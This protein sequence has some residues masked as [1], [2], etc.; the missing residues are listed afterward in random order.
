MKIEI[1]EVSSKKE[2][3]QFVKFPLSLYKGNNYYVPSLISE[4]MNS[5]DNTKNPVFEHAEARY[6]LAYKENKIVGRIAAIINRFEVEKQQKL[7]IRFGWFDVIDDIHVTEALLNKVIELG[8]SRGLN[9]IEGP[10]GFSNMDKAGLLTEGF[11]ERSAM[12]TLYN[13]EYYKTH[14]EKLGFETASEWVENRITI[15]NQLPEKVITISKIV[16]ERYGLTIVRFKNSKDLDPYILPIFSLLEETYNS[17]ESYVP[18]SEKEIKYY[19]KKFMKILKPE[20]ISCIT[21]KEGNLCSFAITCPSYSEAL[22]KAGG[23]LLPFGWYY[24]LNSAKNTKTA[25][26]IL[27][28]IHHK[29]QKKGV[30][31]LIFC[32]I[33]NVLK[34]YHMEYLETNPQL[35]ENLNV[36]LLWTDFNPIVH[37]RRKTFRKSI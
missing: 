33:F 30:T 8:K 29:Y 27:I 37:K 24:L 32:E 9:F 23:K 18:F 3:Q 12:L 15:P 16:Q 5:L 11:N 22:Q 10:V 6:F 17:L 26:S 31:S 4:E 14:L 19:K 28:G 2:L 7:K 20:F 35:V 36:Q 1:R 34:K 21:D 13:H 25:E